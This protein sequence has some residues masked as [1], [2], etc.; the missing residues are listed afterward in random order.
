M[1]VTLTKH[2]GLAAGIRRSP[3]VVESSVLPEPVAAEL[4]K[5]VA[6]LK[7]APVVSEEKPGRARDA[8]TYT[9]SVDEDG[10]VSVFRQS[11]TGMS[12]AFANFL[13]WLE[14]HRAGK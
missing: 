14:R 11:D 1:K 5:L 13:T 6:A 10:Q 9:I 3:D 8:M 7:A 4:V 2:G 12:E